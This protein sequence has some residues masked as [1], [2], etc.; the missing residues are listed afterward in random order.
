[1]ESI[2]RN[3][4]ERK[5]ERHGT[6]FTLSVFKGSKILGPSH[7][8]VQY[9]KGQH[10]KTIKFLANGAT[11]DDKMAVSGNRREMMIAAGNILRNSFTDQF[12]EDLHTRRQ[13][14]R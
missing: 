12:Y 2:A 1:M 8:A 13:V 11:S 4:A 7:V 9:K 14:S 3:W 10:T 5:A 6:T